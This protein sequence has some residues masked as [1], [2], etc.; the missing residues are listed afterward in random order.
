MLHFVT[1]SKNHKLGLNVE[2]G[3]ATHDVGLLYFLE[4]ASEPPPLSLAV[5]GTPCSQVEVELLF[6]NRYLEES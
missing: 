1:R 5:L 4:H 2:A 6:R 3:N